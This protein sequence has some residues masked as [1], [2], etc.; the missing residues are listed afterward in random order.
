MIG[1]RQDR[2][3]N[4]KQRYG[5]ADSTNYKQPRTHWLPIE[6]REAIINYARDCKTR[7]SGIYN[8][9]GYRRLAYMMIDDNVSTCSPSTVYNVLRHTGLLNRWNTNCSTKKGTGFIQPKKVHEHWHI[10]IKYVNY[11]GT[12]L[13]FIGVLDG[14]SRYILHFELRNSMTEFD[15][16]ITLLKAMEKFPKAKARLISDNGKQ[17]IAREFQSFLHNSGFTHVRTSP[18][19]PQSNGKLERFHRSLSEE[20]IR[21]SSFI[22]Q[23]DA[24]RQFTEYV[25][26]YNN[27]R[28]HSALYYLPPITYLNDTYKEK[29]DERKIKMKEGYRKRKR[30]N[31]GKVA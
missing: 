20:C 15:I 21:V 27:E 9:D 13:Y 26:Y 6:E 16:I 22:D 28:L 5:I 8:R 18:M 23:D 14:F 17:F 7:S 10:D 31:L 12:F 19:Y 4:W 3:Y 24:K 2:Y 25:E 29:I 30:K 11:Q 1:I